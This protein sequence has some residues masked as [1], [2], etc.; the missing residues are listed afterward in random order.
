MACKW[1]IEQITGRT[2]SLTLEQVP[3]APKTYFI[4]PLTKRD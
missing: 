1:A 2:V 3:P 4:R